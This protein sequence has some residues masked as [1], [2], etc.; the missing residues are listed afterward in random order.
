MATTK[1]RVQVTLDPEMYAVLRDLAALNRQ[2]LSAVISEL[3]HAVAPTVY[4]VVEAGR[5]F[6]ALSEGMQDQ[7][8][9]TFT[10]AEARIAPAVEALTEEA[11]ALLAVVGG[12]EQDPRPVTRGSRPPLSMSPPEDSGA[13]T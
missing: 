3:L 4:R 7:V 5:R 6:Q 12:A 10:A 8:R 9:G 11:L 2:S 1:P 13:S